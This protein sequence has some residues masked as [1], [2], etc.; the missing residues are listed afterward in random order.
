MAGAS[1]FQRPAKPV[2]PDLKAAMD[3]SYRLYAKRLDRW[4][5]EDKRTMRAKLA[6]DAARK[7]V[8]RAM[9]G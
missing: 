3:A 2:D 4:G 6:A 8:A 7:D 1:R 5:E 9:R